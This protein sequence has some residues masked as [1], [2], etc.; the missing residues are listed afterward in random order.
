MI[1]VMSKKSEKEIV[2]E[3]FQLFK[4]PWEFYRDDG[5]YSVVLTTHETISESD[6]KLVLV[7]NSERTSFDTETGTDLANAPSGSCLKT[8]GIE[9]PL[10]GKVAAFNAF[11]NSIKKLEI[12][13]GQTVGIEANENGGRTIRLGFDLFQEIRYL[14]TKGQPVEFSRIPTLDWHI[15]ILRKW[16]LESGVPVVEIPPVP[17]GYSFAGCLTHDIDF[18]GIRKHKFDH[19][20]LG[21]LYR[22]LLGSL[23]NVIKRRGS[24]SK[25]YKNWKA[26]FALP[27]VYLGV[28]EDFWMP[29]DRY[30]RIEK[31]IHS[32]FFIIPFK[33]CS[34]QGDEPGHSRRATGYDCSDVKEEISSL[35]KEGCEIGVHGIDAWRD[36]AKGL[37]ELARIREATGVSELGTR[38]H[39]LYFDDN[40]PRILERAGFSYDSTLG[41]NDAVGY[42]PGTVQVYRHLGVQRLLELPMNIQDTALFFP[43]RMG[44]KEE[45]A[46]R[47]ITELLENSG[48]FGGAVTI[49]WH[50]RSLVPERLWGDIFIKIIDR[51]KQLNVWMDTAARVVRWFD[52]RRSAIFE[53]VSFS[54][55]S[56]RLKVGGIREDDLPG[57]TVRIHNPIMES[58]EGYRDF[59]LAS[60]F[61]AEYP[62]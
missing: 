20:M 52:K 39:W 8:D 28:A 59:H 53:D 6:A 47:L 16:I 46:W 45:D 10:Y 27:A 7:Y 14:L 55:S 24:W 40:S 62:I 1:G 19:T 60:S 31:D 13:T 48:R 2:R 18:A 9:I 3:F 12:L 37:D 41:Y 36:A 29:F 43:D 25:L 56:V 38:M 50:D 42:R 34:G 33:D 32:T 49:N 51:L 30:R 15:S 17:A 61:E 54:E 21:F 57:L 22:A 11:G 23:V 35:V 5:Q 26:A 44:L 58:V 4:T